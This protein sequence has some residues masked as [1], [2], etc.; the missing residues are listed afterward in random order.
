[1]EESAGMDR[2]MFDR[3]MEAAA[4]EDGGERAVNR[5]MFDRFMEAAAMLIEFTSCSCNCH[6]LADRLVPLAGH[7][8]PCCS[9]PCSSKRSPNVLEA[10]KESVW[11][12]LSGG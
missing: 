5:E 4:I 3:L 11:K 9:F 8:I 7:N 10:I 6:R 12:V 1:M 2:G